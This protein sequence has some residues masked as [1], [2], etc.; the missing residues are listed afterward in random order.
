MLGAYI[1]ERIQDGA[2]EA[3]KIFVT[4]RHGNPLHQQDLRKIIRVAVR[5]AGITKPVSPHLFRHSLAMAM[6]NRGASVMTI[7][8]QL[9]HSWIQ[10]TMDYLRGEYTRGQHEY[11]LT[12][13]NYGV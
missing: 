3:D 9:G 4:R 13:P 2:S 11:P 7:Q 12:A 1:Q 6:L 8:K 10:T 5:R